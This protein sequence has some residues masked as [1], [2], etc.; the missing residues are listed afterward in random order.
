MGRSRS[1][2]FALILY[3]RT[4]H[5]KLDDLVDTKLLEKH[6][7]NKMIK[8]IEERNHGLTIYDYSRECQYK[9]LW[10]DVTTVCRGLVVRSD[11]NEIVARPFKKFFNYNEGIKLP[12]HKFDIMEKLDG[13]MLNVFYH[14]DK[15]ITTTRGS[16]HSDMAKEAM[17]MLQ[18]DRYAWIRDFVKQENEN[19]RTVVFE[20]IYPGNRVV[21]NYNG[22]RRLVLLDI[23]D[24]ETAMHYLTADIAGHLRDKYNA[25]VAKFYPYTDINNI[26]KE[27]ENNDDEGLVVRFENG[28]RYK[29]KWDTYKRLHYLLTE[30]TNKSIWRNM[31]DG[32]DMDLI[33]DK[34]PDEFDAWFRQAREKLQKAYDDMYDIHYN[35]VDYELSVFYDIG[36]ARG[37][38]RFIKKSIAEAVDK[39]VAR[40]KKYGR[41]N[42]NSSLLI[43]IMYGDTP[44]IEKIIWEAIEPKTVERPIVNFDGE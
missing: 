14:N 40:E 21:V 33:L 36:K 12:Q 43:A 39:I 24:N 9:E 29:F 34:I 31:K 42:L 16:F 37:S 17:I 19:G 35:I 5:M 13:S 10:D 41:K 2:F 18:E 28:E 32:V 4:Q 1:L 30:F 38:S 44:Q 8:K 26:K 11:D 15:I 27:F 23:L 22:A 6:I 25:D 3:G 20:C 7:T